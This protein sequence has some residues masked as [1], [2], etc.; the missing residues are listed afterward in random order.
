MNRRQRKVRAKRRSQQWASEKVLQA[1][2]DG[3]YCAEQGAEGMTVTWEL[4][5]GNTYVYTPWKVAKR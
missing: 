4:T 3:F 5:H 1:L 2:V